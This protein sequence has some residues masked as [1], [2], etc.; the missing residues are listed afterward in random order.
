MHGEE[1][2]ADCVA[3]LQFEPADVEVLAIGFDPGELGKAPFR[4]PLRLAME[5]RAKA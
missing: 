1:V 5:E 2:E 3:G 4:K